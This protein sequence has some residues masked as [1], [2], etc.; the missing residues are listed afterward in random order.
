MPNPHIVDDFPFSI[1]QLTSSFLAFH[2]SLYGQT[3]N[4]SRMKKVA[5]IA[6]VMLVTLINFAYAQK[7]EVVVSNKPGWHKIGEVKADFKMENQSISV[8]GAD[9]FKSIKLKVTDAPINIENVK[10]FY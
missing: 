7:P 4:Q 8:L 3:I 5:I 2:F 10:F 1:N 9:K 6:V